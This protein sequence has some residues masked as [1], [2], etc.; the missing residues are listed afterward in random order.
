M[1]Q[2]TKLES[3]GND[4]LLIKS[5]EKLSSDKILKTAHR[6]LGI[7]CDQVLLLSKSKIAEY[8][9]TI[10]NQDGNTASMC[11]N[12]LRAI[13]CFS[14]KDK[15]TVELNG[16][17]YILNREDDNLYKVILSKPNTRIK[18]I[19][20]DKFL[21]SSGYLVELE[22]RHL[23]L[24]IFKEVKLDYGK[25][26][27]YMQK[28]FIGGIN[29]T[30]V[31]NITSDRMFLSTWER[32]VGETESS[33]S[34]AMAVF[35]ALSSLDILDKEVIAVFRYGTMLLK[36]EENLCISSIAPCNLI[37]SGELYV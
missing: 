2:Y 23:I 22:N 30:F 17:V 16:K 10:F 33:G 9:L 15:L 20:I 35:H 25:V 34:S 28:K 31:K 6:K 29:I 32:G 24:P 1:L 7:G 21:L 12:G 13:V 19:D 14:K 3:L 4:F 8:K 26:F 5:N 36:E 27:S 18:K 37:S 11:V